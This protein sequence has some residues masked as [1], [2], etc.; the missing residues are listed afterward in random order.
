M[1]KTTRPARKGGAPNWKE[2]H[3][4][5]TIQRHSPI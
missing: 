1:K 5:D 3:N 4:V 2:T